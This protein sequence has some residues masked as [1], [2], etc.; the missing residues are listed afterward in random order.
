[1]SY[2]RWRRIKELAALD[3]PWLTRFIG[4]DGQGAAPAETW[5]GYY[6]TGVYDGLLRPERRHQ[7]RLLAALV[8]EACPQ[9][10][11]L[12]IG[13]GDGAFYE[14]LRLYGPRRYLGVDISETAIHR[15]QAR[16]GA[17]AGDVAF[18]VGV[19]EAYDAGTERFDAIVF[20]DCIE[21][22]GALPPLFAHYTPYLADGGR[23]AALQWLAPR[24]IALWTEIRALLD[25]EDEAVVQTRWGG[26][27]HLWTARPRG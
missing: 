27:W 26:A 9:G 13:C 6:E 12:E 3:H 22:L 16:R 8:A 5:N 17:D 20:T 24:P 14:S 7:H 25:I 19:G 11:V 15:L 18:R 1:M 4:R 2:L 23:F 21:Y 10:R